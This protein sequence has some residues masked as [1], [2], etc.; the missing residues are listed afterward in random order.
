MKKTTFLCLLLS[1][2]ITPSVYA[3]FHYEINATATLQAN[4]KKQLK[5]IAM[6]WVYNEEVSGI[7]LRADQTL[8]DLSDGIMS[9]LLK[10][11]YF[12]RLEFNGKTVATTD[13]TSYKLEKITQNNKNL[14]KLSFVLPL[15]SPLYLQGKN[16][17]SIIHTDA[18]ASASVFYRN[19]NHLI[20]GSSFTSFCKPSVSAVKDFSHGEVPETVNINCRAN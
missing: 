8:N 3:H 4:E 1:L 14:L 13:V 6:S 16:T 17:L 11:D 10:L 18:G 7:M 19:T 2:L 12:T 20:V 5:A 9:D 15:K